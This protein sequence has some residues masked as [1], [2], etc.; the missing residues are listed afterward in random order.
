MDTLEK[1]Y[2]TLE[3][4]QTE[5]DILQRHIASNTDAEDIKYCKEQLKVI[6]DYMQHIQ[7]GI[8]WHISSQEE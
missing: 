2:S 6:D 8:E 3:A 1:M 7:D 5:T 4:L